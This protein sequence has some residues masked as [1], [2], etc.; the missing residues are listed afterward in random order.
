KDAIHNNP[1]S[2]K[3]WIAC[4]DS[5]GMERF[6]KAGK[7]NRNNDNFQ[8]WQQDNHPI[9]LLNPKIYYQKVD[10]THYNPVKAGFV[11]VLEHYL[12]SSARDYYASQ[13]GLPD[14]VMLES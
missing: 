7:A 10:Y 8:F 9:V 2:R 3:E 12:Y 14:L 13:K 1:E 11:E 4:P 6:T 5:S